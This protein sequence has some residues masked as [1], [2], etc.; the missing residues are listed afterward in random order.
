MNNNFAE[1]ASSHHKDN[2][3]VASPIPGVRRHPLDRVGSE[4]ARATSIVQYDPGSAFSP[5]THTGGEEF[6]VLDG[7]FQDEHGDY[8]AGTYVRNPPTSSHT[9]GAEPGCV[10][11]VKLWQ[12]SPEDRTFIR[13]D[14]NK[15]TPLPDA[16]RSGVSIVPLFDDG[17]EQVCIEHWPAD[18]SVKL[19]AGFGLEVFV[20]N[21][22]FEHSD[23]A[24]ATWS[25]LRM[26]VGDTATVLTGD[27]GTRVWIKRNHLRFAD[28][29]AA[30]VLDA[31]E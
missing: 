20:I 31:A 6:L 17:R 1:P 25:W 26:P 14:V 7:V 10:I 29:E 5:H 3:W 4:V 12:F 18:A 2:A 11:F 22:S 15:I 23:E 13:T 19:E 16:D 21:G 8:P 24:F 9:P 27:R 28:E 30:R